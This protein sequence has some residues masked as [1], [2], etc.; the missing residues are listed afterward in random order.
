MEADLFTRILEIGE[1]NQGVIEHMRAVMK[2]AALRDREFKQARAAK[3]LTLRA[4]GVPVSMLKDLAEGDEEV[5]LA[6]FRSLCAD[7]DAASDKELIQ[8][9]KKIMDTLKSQMEFERVGRTGYE[10]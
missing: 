1:Q 3:E 4:G 5:S 2:E 8:N 10:Y 6:K 9:N 7:A